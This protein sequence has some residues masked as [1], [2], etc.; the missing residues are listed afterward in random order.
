MLRYP[1]LHPQLIAAVA[2]AGHG[3]RILIADANYAHATNVH[4][5]TELVS[6][7]LRPGL[8]AVDDILETLQTA[9]P[10]ESVQVMRPDDG[11]TPE[12]W[13]RYRE[14]LGDDLPLEPLDRGAFYDTCR[15]PELALCVA[16]GDQR[17]YANV[18]LTV[19]FVP[20]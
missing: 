5:D 18:L 15:Q 9:I 16:S 2:R 8:I 4:P 13:S 20:H 11:T 19:G 1:L 12:V 3:S 7:N 6:L 10:I 14:L 17:L